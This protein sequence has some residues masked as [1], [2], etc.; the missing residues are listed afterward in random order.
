M[1]TIKLTLWAVVAAVI[2][3]VFIAC[4]MLGH[5][6]GEADAIGAVCVSF[7]RP[8]DRLA[9]WLHLPQTAAMIF[10]FAGAFIELFVPL[11]L[12]LLGVRY[13]R[14]RHAV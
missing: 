12:I 11:W 6:G 10:M 8:G 4:L 13:F 5:V 7:F 9:F 3:E 1:S 2:A 14:R